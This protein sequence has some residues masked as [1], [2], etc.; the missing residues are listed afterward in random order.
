LR[1][2]AGNWGG[3]IFGVVAT[4]ACI[5][6]V[7]AWGCVLDYQKSSLAHRR[8]Q[9]RDQVQP[10]MADVQPTRVSTPGSTK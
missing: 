9:S 5:V 6:A 3:I 4:S 1:P 10:L 2:R 7:I 8:K